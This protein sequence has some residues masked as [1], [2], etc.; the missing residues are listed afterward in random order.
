MTDIPTPPELSAIPESAWAE[1][2]RYFPVF[3][4]LANTPKRNRSQ[5]IAAAAELG[6]SRSLVYKLLRRFIADPRLTSL[7]SH[8]R[9]P[10]RGG[11]RLSSEIHRLIDEMI[12]SVYLTPQRPRLT[13]LVTEVRQRCR[14]MGLK[15]PSRKR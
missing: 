2:R 9:G 15:A 13:D 11:S 10:T 4:R 8:Q 1:A 3:H 7:L 6:C 5:V 12:E 14:A